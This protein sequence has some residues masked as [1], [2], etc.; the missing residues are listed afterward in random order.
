MN[1]A[2]VETIMPQHKKATLRPYQNK[3]ISEVFT[4]LKDGFKKILL[5]LAMGLGKTTVMSAIIEMG[6]S[7]G[8]RILVVVHRD[9]LVRQFAERLSEQFNVP[10]GLIL[11]TEPKNYS[12]PIQIASRQS[13]IRRLTVFPPNHFDLII[14]DEAHYAAAPEYKKILEYFDQA[15]LVGITATP[16]RAD[17]KPLKGL[18]DKM[19]HPIKAKEAINQGFLIP[20]VYHGVASIDM[21]GIKLNRKGEYDETEMFARFREW[22]ITPHVVSQLKN[23]T[24]PTLIFCINVE[25]TI[26]VYNACKAAG[27]KTEYVVGEIDVA[28]RNIYYKKFKNKEIDILVNCQIL[29][30]GA[31]FPMVTNV[32]IVKKMRSLANYLQMVGR[33]ARPYSD[34]SLFDK[35]EFYVVDFGGNVEEHGFFEDYDEGLTLTEGAEKKAGKPKPKKCPSCNKVLPQQSRECPECAYVFESE[36]VEKIT[37]GSVE[38]TVLSKNAINYM[39]LSKKKWEQVKDHELRLYAKIKGMKPG[40]ALHQYAERHS[41]AKTH[42]WHI[43]VNIVLAD[44]ELPYKDLYQ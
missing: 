21:H 30:E 3:A 14:V 19:I 34:G 25:H 29:T 43:H 15:K 17:G 39:R 27:Y 24:G 9:N 28:Q 44:L 32:F 18:F 2:S 5:V 1:N 26:E 7:K 42:N 33:G 6:Y 23:Y 13:L 37:I 31:D 16:F 38:M 12:F 36:P 11:G 41:I 8:R 20:A 35:K 40:W 4:A 10:S 22:D